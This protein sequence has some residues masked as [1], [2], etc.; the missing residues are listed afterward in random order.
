MQQARIF[1]G[2]LNG[3]FDVLAAH[4]VRLDSDRRHNARNIPAKVM[5]RFLSRQQIHYYADNIAVSE[6]L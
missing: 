4:I 1:K 6:I 5:F 3:C 2:K